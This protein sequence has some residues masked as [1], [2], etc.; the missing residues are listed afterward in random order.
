M[1]KFKLGDMLAVSDFREGEVELI[2][3]EDGVIRKG[4]WRIPDA[5]LE[6]IP[7]LKASEVIRSFENTFANLPK[8]VAKGVSE[9]KLGPIITKTLAPQVK[10]PWYRCNVCGS[11]FKGEGCLDIW[12]MNCSPEYP[13]TDWFTNSDVNDLDY[14]GEGT[15]NEPPPGDECAHPDRPLDQ[16]CQDCPR[17]ADPPWCTCFGDHECEGHRA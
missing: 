1:M 11:R 10:W 7:K 9:L 14:L 16:L 2:G 6:Q 13:D 8:E 12:C 17:R 5:Y 15:F 3:F 4:W